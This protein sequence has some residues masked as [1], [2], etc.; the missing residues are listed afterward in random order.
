MKIWLDDNRDPTEWL[1]YQHWWRKDPAATLEGWVWVRTAPEVIAWL[2]VG[3]VDEMSLDHDLGPTPGAGTGQ[4]V[5]DWIDEQVVTTEHYEPPVIHIPSGNL[6]GHDSLERTRATIYRHLVERTRR[7]AGNVENGPMGLGL[8]MVLRLRR[9]P[10]SGDQPILPVELNGREASGN[11]GAHLLGSWA[12]EEDE[13]A[14]PYFTCFLPGVLYGPGLLFN[15]D[16][17]PSAVGGRADSLSRPCRSKGQ[18]DAAL[19]GDCELP[20]RCAGVQ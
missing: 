4:E 12:S 17:G 10:M 3:A 20:V 8:G 19:F 11:S 9:R 16:G 1:P 5:L 14:P 18:T 7:Q 13:E 15:I 6:P 2:S